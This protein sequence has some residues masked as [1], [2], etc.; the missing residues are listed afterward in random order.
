MSYQICGQSLRETHNSQ[1]LPWIFD[2][3]ESDIPRLS[4]DLDFRF[5]RGR[6]TL[7]G[8]ADGVDLVFRNSSCS[9]SMSSSVSSLQGRLT[10]DAI[11]TDWNTNSDMQYIAKTNSN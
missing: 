7:T 9:R 2:E 1:N 4:V 3:S 10:N 6:V 11:G 5:S 8:R